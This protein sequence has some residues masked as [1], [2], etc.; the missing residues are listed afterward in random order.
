MMEKVQRLLET[1]MSK[2]RNSARYNVNCKD[3]V[4]R[5][6][7]ALISLS[8]LSDD[9][10]RHAKSG[11]WWISNP[12][13][14]LANNSAVYTEKPNAETFIREWGSLIESK[15]GERGIFNRVSS[16]LAAGRSRRRDT[17]HDFGTN[18]CLV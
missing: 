17:G 13:F 8:N 12:E 18:P 6:R 15:S 14:T 9:R 10:M 1:W 5:R 7:S 11:E 16:Q 2:T 4:Q 3:I